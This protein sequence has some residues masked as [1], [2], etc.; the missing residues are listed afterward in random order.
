MTAAL[1]YTHLQIVGIGTTHKHVHIVIGLHYN[2][3]RSARK[4]DGLICNTSDISHYHKSVSL[5]LYRISHSLR[6]RRFT[7]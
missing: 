6:P 3:V 7:A 1:D 4:L 5:H 2:S